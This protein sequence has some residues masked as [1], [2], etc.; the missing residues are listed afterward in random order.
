[1]NNKLLSPIVIIALIFVGIGFASVA[2]AV[3]FT[4]GKSEFWINKKMKIG[5][6]L[7]SL[8]SILSCGGSKIT[9]TCYDTATTDN[10][11][12]DSQNQ[13]QKIE[14]TGQGQDN[15][16]N[17]E[18]TL[19]CYD[20]VVL[21]PQIFE[22]DIIDISNSK[23]LKGIVPQNYDRQYTYEIKKDEE[24]IQ[25]GNIKN[26]KSDGNFTI[27]LNDKIKS[28]TYYFLIYEGDDYTILKYSQE[29]TVK[30]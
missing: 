5:G 12:N 9:A 7:L 22:N 17:S 23:E 21:P 28:G 25:K 19:L 20:V 24:T 6:I 8:T 30:E 10:N 27:K 4:K 2:I 11:K 18:L 29:I 13:I 3:Y 15:G 26:N 14:N 1:M 16:N